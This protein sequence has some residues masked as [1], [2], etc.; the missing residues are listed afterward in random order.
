MK[1]ITRLVHFDSNLAICQASLG[2]EDERIEVYASAQADEAANYADLAQ[3]RA[4]QL[5]W[6]LKEQGVD[7]LDALE[8]RTPSA[9]SVSRAAPEVER[10]IPPA[11]AEMKQDF[12]ASV[13]VGAPDAETDESVDI[14]E[15]PW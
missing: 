6:Q 11:K 2:A 14:P 4:V 7:A 15:Q 9:S 8:L 3:K 12:D 5:A 1:L 13:I 10:K